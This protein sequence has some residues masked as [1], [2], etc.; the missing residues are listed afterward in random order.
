MNKAAKLVAESILG[1]YFK[2]FVMGGRAYKIKEPTI[3][4]I[5]NAITEYSVVDK[6]KIKAGDYLEIKEYYVRLL[7]AL[8]VFVYGDKDRWVEFK[9]GTANEM[10]QAHNI[11]TELLTPSGFFL[12][13]ALAVR[14]SE[15]AAKQK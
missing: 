12:S 3:E 15:M 6:E 10:G 9:G 14:I 1:N 5:L 8:A 13:A 7:K 2:S 11:V 4:T